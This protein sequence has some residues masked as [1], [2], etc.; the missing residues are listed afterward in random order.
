MGHAD[1]LCCCAATDVLEKWPGVKLTCKTP[2]ASSQRAPS[3]G[4]I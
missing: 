1:S 4:E 2:L 3:L